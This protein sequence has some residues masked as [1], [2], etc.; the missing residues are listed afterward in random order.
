MKPHEQAK[1]WRTARGLTLDQLA[2]LTGYSVPAIRKF[3]QGARNEKRGERHS[4]WT[5]Q[6]YQ[7]ACAG[8]EAQIKSGREFTW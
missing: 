4:Q 8:A 1:A 6:R 5:W 2:D 3:E 7:M